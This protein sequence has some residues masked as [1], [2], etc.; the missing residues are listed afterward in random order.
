MSVRRKGTGQN[1]EIPLPARGSDVPIPDARIDMGPPPEIDI[2]S[3]QLGALFTER[4]RVLGLKVEEVAED[5]KIKPEYLRAIEREEFEFLPT[6][7][8]ARLFVRTYAERLGFN[9]AEVYALLDVNAAMLSIA[10]KPKHSAPPQATQTQLSGPLPG[11]QAMPP[12]EPRRPAGMGMWIGIIV[13]VIVLALIV[14]YVM[15][16]L[17]GDSETSDRPTAPQTVAQ[18]PVNAAETMAEDVVED[19]VPV[20]AAV[21]EWESLH[22]VIH[23]NKETW[24]SLL[25]DGDQVTNAIFQPG[26]ELDAYAAQTFR[27]SLGHTDGVTATINGHPMR[28]FNTWANKLEGHLINRDTARVWEDTTAVTGAAGAAPAPHLT[29]DMTGPPTPSGAGGTL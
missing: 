21:D 28:A 13:S 1:G 10:G 4:R 24:A 18:T 2:A 14:W 25:A 20:A 7:Q 17:N 11:T 23:F 22:L 27:L 26:S 5:I 3:D 16:K 8:Y 9:P 15:T 12:P 29:A 6:P 19:S